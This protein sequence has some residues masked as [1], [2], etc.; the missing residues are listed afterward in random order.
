MIMGRFRSSINSTDKSHIDAVHELMERLGIRGGLEQLDYLISQ[1][2]HDFILNQ[3]P[4]AGD[5]ILKRATGKSRDEWLSI[6]S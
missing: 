5:R 1:N 2:P 4:V 6:M 3:A